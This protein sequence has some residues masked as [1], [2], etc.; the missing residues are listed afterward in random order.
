MAERRRKRR[1][2]AAARRR[3]P[4]GPERVRVDTPPGATAELTFPW[5][6][7]LSIGWGASPAPQP[8]PN[9]PLAR[10]RRRVAE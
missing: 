9:P 8:G 3:Q 6:S 4:L 10:T 1:G 7:A 2:D 5:A